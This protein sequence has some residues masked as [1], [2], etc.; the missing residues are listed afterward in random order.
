[1]AEAQ[2]IT[3]PYTGLDQAEQPFGLSE[4]L[5]G[6]LWQPNFPTADFVEASASAL[7]DQPAGHVQEGPS[8]RIT[9]SPG[10][11]KIW[12]KDE[13]RHE[14]TENRALDAR[15]KITDAQAVFIELGD[16]GE[17]LS[18][19]PERVPSREI[20][21]WSAKSRARMVERLCDLDYAPLFSDPTRLPAMVTLTYPGCWL[22]AAPNGKTAKRHMKAFRKRYERAYG[23]TLYTVWKFEFQARMEYVW[24]NGERVYNWCACEHC[25]GLDDGRA[26]HIHML[27]SPPHQLV[28]GMNFKEWLSRTWA[29]I[30]NHPDEQQYANHIAAGTSIGWNDGLRCTDPRRI[31]VYFTKHGAFAAKQYQHCVPQAWQEPGKGPGRFWG[32]WGLK[33]VTATRAVSPEIGTQ[34]G[35]IVRRHSKAQQVTREVRRPRAKGGVP[36]SKYPEVIGLAGAMLMQSRTVR[37]RK[38]RTRAVRAKNGRGW[39]SLNSGPDFATEL[40]FALHQYR[41]QKHA[42]HLARAVDRGGW[43]T[44]L[45]RAEQL[46]PSSRRDALIARLRARGHQ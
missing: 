39:V 7:P 33:P 16:D 6:E 43:N 42:D 27:M 5:L 28:D 2:T 37:Y 13:A 18:D 45:R 24:K 25:D 12:T 30:V 44:P 17:L 38:T 20:T 9:V 36:R 32:Y 21:G 29:D 35:R 41:A 4:N 31:A 14:R 26:P 46:P 10:K 40:G 3:V 8:W 22:R 34:A 19:V 15:Q 11:V 1:V 23:E